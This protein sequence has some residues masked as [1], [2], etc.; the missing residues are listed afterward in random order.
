LFGR[1]K[2][3]FQF[4]KGDI[5]LACDGCTSEEMERLICLILGEEAVRDPEEEIAKFREM[6]EKKGD[7]HE[8]VSTEGKDIEMVDVERELKTAKLPN[9][10]SNFTCPGCDQSIL[11]INDGKT[12]VRD[13]RNH[14]LYDIGEL[15][16]P[17]MR[18]TH[19]DISE[20]LVIAVYK[21]C[22]DMIDRTKEFVLV[23]GSKEKCSCPVCKHEGTVE[24]FIKYNEENY[25]DG[26]VCDICGCEKD[27]VISQEG[28]HFD[29][30][31]HCLEKLGKLYE[32]DK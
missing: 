22:Y 21:D 11:L 2:V 9:C 8:F 30:V 32:E 6:I 14:K 20:D 25:N 17:D 3:N 28:E 1:R 18:D 5:S 23:S 29:C 10:T 19:E 24:E 4:T 7:L 12:L 13:Y 16:L 15:Q 31:N 27:N 26:E